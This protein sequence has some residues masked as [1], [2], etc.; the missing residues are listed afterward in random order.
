[1]FRIISGYVLT[2]KKSDTDGFLRFYDSYKDYQKRKPFI[3]EQ[4]ELIKK[5]VI[6][7]EEIDKTLPM[8]AKGGRIGV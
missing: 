8:L 5:G 2:G 4:K 6:K 1:M 3:E 7:E